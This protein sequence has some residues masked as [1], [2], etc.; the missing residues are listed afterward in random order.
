MEHSGFDADIWKNGRELQEALSEEGK[1]DFAYLVEHMRDL[2]HANIYEFDLQFEGFL[3]DLKDRA[4]FDP[5]QLVFVSD[6]GESFL[7]HHSLFHG[8]VL[9]EEEIRVPFFVYGSG[10]EAGRSS[11][12][13]SLVDLVPT[14]ALLAGLDRREEWQGHSVLSELPERTLYAF[15][16]S[17]KKISTWAQIRG[18]HKWLGL[19]RE[20]EPGLDGAFA[21]FDLSVD[22][23]EQADQLDQAP[24]AAE[25]TRSAAE[26]RPALFEA[27]FGAESSGRSEELDNVMRALGYMG[28]EE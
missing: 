25:L 18:E 17:K 28:D 26:A 14:L 15:Q 8:N 24:W 3:Q 6:H 7:R 2:Y 10:I 23:E 12:P 21:A 11:V 20:L 22:P 19:E 13:V 5:G 1:R 27:R 4:F 16:C 9:Y